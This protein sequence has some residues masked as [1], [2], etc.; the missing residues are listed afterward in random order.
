MGDVVGTK[1]WRS[2]PMHLREVPE[3][4]RFI[5]SLLSDSLGKAMAAKETLNKVQQNVINSER[6]FGR[7]PSDSISSSV[8]APGESTTT[9]VANLKQLTEYCDFGDVLN[10]ML[11]DRLVCGAKDEAIQHRLLAEV[12]IDF[13]H[14]LEISLAMESA[15]RDSQALSHKE[16]GTVLHAGWK[17][18]AKCGVKTRAA[19]LK[20]N[21]MAIV[22]NS[23][24]PNRNASS[25]VSRGQIPEEFQSL[26]GAEADLWEAEMVLKALNSIRSGCI[27]D[28]LNSIM[29]HSRKTE[30]AELTLGQEE[31]KQPFAADSNI[32]DE[33]LEQL[34]LENKNLVKNFNTE[35]TLRK[36]YYNMVEDLKGKIRVFCRIRPLSKSELARGRQSIVHFPDEYTVIIKSSRGAKEFQ[37]DQVFNCSTSQE[38][39]F[40]DTNRLIQSAVDGY[41]VCIFAYGQTGSGKTFT[42]IGEKE[43]ANPGIIPKTFKRI[44]QVI[45]ENQTK[46]AFKVLAYMLELYNDQL[47]DLFINRCE[48]STTKLEIRK[49]KK[50]FVYIQGAEIKEV[51]NAEMLCALFE[52][53]CKN[54]HT[55]ATKMNTESSRSHLIVGV[56]I[57]STNLTNGTV[58]YGKLSMVD[59][60]GSERASKTGAEDEQLKEA[61]SINKSLSSLGDVISALSAE[62][63]FIPYRNN[64]LTLLMQD[65]LGGNSKTLMFVNISPADCNAEESI[66]SLIYASRVKLI[67][68]NAQKNSET[69]EIA[70][71]KQ[72]IAKLKSGEAVEEAY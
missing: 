35:R 27:S 55:A 4:Q 62:Q 67:T 3:A 9:Y 1:C 41:N 46:F 30:E 49:D 63:S 69:K 51:T 43:Q 60:A 45:D 61:N 72:I 31:I 28:Q 58:T 10:D 29:A 39:I 34:K 70:R 32:I 54:R 15:A 25:L 40:R 36:K 38:E 59:L 65:S 23:K 48:G 17:T 2:V 68:N 8:Q 14:A 53:G 56:T 18:A 22:R 7:K 52:Q 26:E 66:S 37:F 42:M 33:Q 44:F 19:E 47:L 20:C 11:R 24:K 64:K 71:L 57:K 50:G 5:D 6:T 16:N 13:K 12:D 21:S